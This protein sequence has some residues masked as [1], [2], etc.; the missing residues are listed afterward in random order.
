[1]AI[2]I[3]IICSF[4]SVKKSMYVHFSLSIGYREYILFVVLV[5]VLLQEMLLYFCLELSHSFILKV[6]LLSIFRSLYRIIS[7]CYSSLSYYIVLV[8]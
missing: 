4:S 6:N 8:C 2:A 7:E 3:S 5:L 1:M